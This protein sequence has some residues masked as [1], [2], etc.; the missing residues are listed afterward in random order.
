MMLHELVTRDCVSGKI[1]LAISSLLYSIFGVRDDNTADRDV[2]ALD[3]VNDI[4]R[5][6]GKV[7]NLKEVMRFFYI[8]L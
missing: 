6:P 1:D 5:P 3:Y 2:F 4:A 8:P 7:M